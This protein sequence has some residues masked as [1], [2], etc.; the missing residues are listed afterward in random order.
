MTVHRAEPQL[1][2]QLKTNLP[3]IKEHRE[4]PQPHNRFK[5]NLLPIRELLRP[6]KT[7]RPQ[8]EDN[9]N[10]DDIKKSRDAINRV[11]TFFTFATPLRSP[12]G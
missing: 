9:K 12:S 5:I 3:P 4:E 1:Y 10:V 6:D 7:Q 2:S 8:A 11:S